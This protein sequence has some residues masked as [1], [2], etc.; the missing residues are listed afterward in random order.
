MGLV[1]FNLEGDDVQRCLDISS[2]VACKNY[3]PDQ[4][5]CLYNSNKFSLLHLN[6]R[7]LNK[8]H[9][10]LVALLHTLQCNFN[11][12]GCTE[13]WLNDKSYVNILNLDGY[14][15]HHKN[16]QDRVGGGVCLYSHSSMHVNVRD[17]L[18]INDNH[19]ESLFIEIDNKTGK[20]LVVGVIYRPPNSDPSAF[21]EKL[22][23]LLLII[24]KSNKDSIILGDFNIDLS[25]D[26][27]TKNNFINTLH[28]CS[29][30]PTIN[31]PTRV[32][33]SSRTVIDN[34][35]TNIHNTKFESGVLMYDISDH[36]PTVLFGTLAR[37][38]TQTHHPVKT[39]VLNEQPKCESSGQRMGH[40]LPL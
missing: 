27:S 13:T 7:S 40:C 12:I 10:D 38:G 15:L 4:L 16:R 8:H 3:F 30:Y 21:I 17:D 2:N 32:T 29:F 19:S 18:T 6:I 9:D 26:Y 24:N 14:T 31:I 35:I 33:D 1:D 28:S 39:R 25:K 34:I 11:I 22:D 37:K 23:E 20:N 36:Y 5:K